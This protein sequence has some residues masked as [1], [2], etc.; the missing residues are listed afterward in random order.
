M[1]AMEHSQRRRWVEE[2][3]QI[4]RRLNA[5]TGQIDFIAREV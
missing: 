3:A 2:I 1:M 5:Q 4:N